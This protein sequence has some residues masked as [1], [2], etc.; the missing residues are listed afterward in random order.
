M[1][2]G[3]IELPNNLF[4]APMAGVTDRPFRQQ[5]TVNPDTGEPMAFPRY[6]TQYESGLF[7][8]D[9]WTINSRLSLSL[10]L[11]H[12]YFGTVSER[13]GLLS[14][15]TLGAGET[16]TDQLRGAKIGRVDHLYEPERL[17]FSPRVGLAWDP[18]GNG[19]T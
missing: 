13:D 4:V 18:S 2:I 8:Q 15:I 19:R 10:G 6:F 5:L 3:S 14:S 7:F 17:N 1:K 16:F 9:Q 11:R 12:D